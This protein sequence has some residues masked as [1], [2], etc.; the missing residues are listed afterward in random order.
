M[1]KVAILYSHL[2]ELGGVENVVL[3]QTELLRGRGHDVNCYFAYLDE[4]SLKDLGNP[5]GYARSYFNF[6]ILNHKATRI[7]L[8]VPLA[9]LTLNAFKNADVL[10]CHGYGSASWIGYNLKKIKGVRYISYIHFLPRFLYFDAEA[11]KLWRFD[12]TRRLI[13]ALGKVTRPLLKKSDFIGIS[14]SD[15]VLVNSRFTGRLVKAIYGVQSLVCYPP[16]DTRIY[17]P[18]DNEAVQKIRSR[19][20]WPLILSTGRI[21]PIKR[22]EWLIEMMPYVTR[23][24]PSATLA[25]TGEISSENAEYVQRLIKLAKSLGIRRNMKFLGFRELSE[26]VELYNAAEVYAF[27]PPKEYLGL[28]PV[29]AMA[30]GTPA[31]VWNDGAGPCETVVDGK[32]GF[33]AKPYDLEDF[34]EKVMKTLDMDKLAMCNFAYHHVK[35]SFSHEKHIRSLGEVLRAF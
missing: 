29:E 20:G 24:F 8:S 10:L 14:N 4:R 7:I 22:W 2:K 12:S 25:I 31:V 23:V 17:K 13:D 26:L 19:F 33:R 11:R 9:P 1:L 32:T 18:L 27:Q 30:C 3:K 6:P 34:A 15:R 35:E 5:Y 16:V 21:V 28:G